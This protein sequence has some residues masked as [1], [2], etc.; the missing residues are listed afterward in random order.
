MPRH[1]RFIDLGQRQRRHRLAIIQRNARDS[2]AYEANISPKEDERI[3]DI[4]DSN[5]E[6]SDLERDSERHTLDTDD[7]I[8]QATVKATYKK[9][10]SSVRKKKART[11]PPTRSGR[12]PY[13]NSKYLSSG[14]SGNEAIMQASKL[15]EATKDKVFKEW[16]KLMG[17]NPAGS[18]LFKRPTE[19]VLSPKPTQNRPISPSMSTSSLKSIPSQSQQP[20]KCFPHDSSFPETEKFLREILTGINDFNERTQNFEKRQDIVE[21]KIDKIIIKIDAIEKHLTK[22]TAAQALYKNIIGFPIKSLTDFD[23]MEKP[24]NEETRSQM[25]QRIAVSGARTLRAFCSSALQQLLTDEV[26]S[27]FTWCGTKGKRNFKDSKI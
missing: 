8:V 7:N 4:Q 21:Q 6:S 17:D 16:K 11:L 1:K 14:E 15:P 12:V 5:S 19:K 26:I 2:E 9:E 25:V 20:I 22:P 3:P 18:D 23:E 10:M 27:D 13:S 24:E